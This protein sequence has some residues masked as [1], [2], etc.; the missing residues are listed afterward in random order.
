M[1]FFVDELNGSY[2]C[3][4]ILSVDLIAIIYS[5]QMVHV[6]WVIQMINNAVRKLDV[7]DGFICMV[8]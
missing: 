5:C 6:H 8:D 7:L 1:G 4:K 3:W 2:N